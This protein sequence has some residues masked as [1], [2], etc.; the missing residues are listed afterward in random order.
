MSISDIIPNYIRSLDFETVGT[1][2]IDDQ[3]YEVL[4]VTFEVLQSTT[5]DGH[6]HQVLKLNGQVR[7]KIHYCQNKKDGIDVTYDQQGNKTREDV[8][9]NGEWQTKVLYYAPDE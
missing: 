3:P 6:H 2:T 5:E 7:R 4:R 9:Q 1:Q 8:Y